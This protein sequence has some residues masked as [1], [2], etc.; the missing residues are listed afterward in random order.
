MKFSKVIK[1]T[2]LPLFFIFWFALQVQAQQ[3]PNFS[4]YMFYGLAYNPGLAGNESAVNVTIADRIQWTG[5]GK[6]QGDKV[7]PHTYFVAGDLPIKPLKGGIGLVIMNDALGHENT[8]GV[9]LGYAN[10]RK[11]GFGKLG[12][13]AQIEFNNKNIDFSKLNPAGDDPLLNQLSSKESEM[14]IDFSLGAFYRVPESFY[15]GISA[16]HLVQTK[17]KPLVESSDGSLRMKLDRTFLVT[18]GYELNFPRNPDYTFVPSAIIETNLSTFRFDVD[19]MLRYKDVFWGGL[20]YRLGES[21]IVILG[22][23]FK[24]FRIGYSYD[25]V[26]SKLNLPVFGGTHEIM[27]NYRFKLEMDKG[28]KSY[29]NTRFL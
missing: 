20:G 14:L 15:F 8:I 25:I 3:E 7:A 28:R 12:I 6:E 10:Q 13:G 27:V 17:G 21:V 5:F 11:L 9:K 18:G 24:D 29:K 16:L 26:A 19:A 23:R 22:V 4:Q 2:V 1:V